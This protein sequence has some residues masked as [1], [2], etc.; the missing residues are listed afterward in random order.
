MADCSDTFVPTQSRWRKATPYATIAAGGAALNPGV[1][2]LNIMERLWFI[3]PLG[4]VAVASAV[5][6][7]SSGGTTAAA[8]G[9][10][11]VSGDV[12]AGA[13]AKTDAAAAGETSAATG[14]TVTDTAKA[15]TAATKAPCKPWDLPTDW[16]CPPDTHCGYNDDD[17]IACVADG[18]HA[19]AKDCSDGAGCKIGI[20]VMAQNGSQA[21]SPFCTV[22]AQCDSQSCNQITGKKYKVCDVA[23]YQPCK[24][25]GSTCPKG[26]ACYQQGSQGF[27][28]LGAGTAGK[29][30]ACKTNSDCAPGFTCTGNAGTASSTGL[31]RKV[32]SKT[33][34]T[35]CDDPNTPCSSLGGGYGY[36]E[37]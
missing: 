19:V 36:C 6:C 9:D 17:A 18:K 25:I 31:C 12:A 8:A 32:C 3:R 26:Q 20:C 28:C 35:G 15:D 16:N 11:T 27:V 34:P 2:W 10:S 22:D 7:G 14:D 37:E 24:P 21:C 4:A 5:A 1:D 30:D 29:G 13:D 33:G 23:K